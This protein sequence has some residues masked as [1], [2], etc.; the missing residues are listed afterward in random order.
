MAEIT[1]KWGFGM[2]PVKKD[3][4]TQR[5]EACDVLIDFIKEP[6]LSPPEHVLDAISQT[7]GLFTRVWKQDQ[8]D[9]FTVFDRLGRPGKKKCREISYQLTQLRKFLKNKD[10][11]VQTEEELE[12]R[13]STIFFLKVEK[14]C[15]FYKGLWIPR[16]VVGQIYILSTRE[17]K[18][19]LK[20]G[21]TE[22]SI[23]ERVKEINASTG[24]ITPFGVRAVWAIESAKL[25]E[26]EIHSIFNEFR[27]RKDREFFRL[28]YG[29]AF[30]II[31]KL[32][33]NKRIEEH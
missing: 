14:H 13:L 30:K 12:E 6:F 19:V 20:I 17:Q 5:F 29:D 28:E 1:E 32:I 7:K 23:W 2:A 15:N 22:R 26:R 24:V 31:N 3:T 10:G 4:D 27:I 8:W 11:G 33:I 16:N 25:T 18:D 21:Y 9:W